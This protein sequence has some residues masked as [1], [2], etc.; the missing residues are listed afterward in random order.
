[1]SIVISLFFIKIYMRENCCIKIAKQI[2][3]DSEKYRDF[4][5]FFEMALSKLVIK[6]IS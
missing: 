6:R 2:L 3:Q 5:F 4:I 1:M